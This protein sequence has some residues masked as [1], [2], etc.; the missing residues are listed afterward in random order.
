MELGYTV[1]TPQIGKI[2]NGTYSAFL[3]S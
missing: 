3:A 1:G 2:R